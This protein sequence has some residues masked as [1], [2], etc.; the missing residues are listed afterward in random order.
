MTIDIARLRELCEKANINAQPSPLSVSDLSGRQFGRLTVAGWH[1]RGSKWK[2]HWTCVCSCG[3]LVVVS[4]DNL[5]RKSGTVSCGCWKR[6][7]GNPKHMMCY[8]TEYQIWSS[9]RKRCQNANCHAFKDY[10]ARGIFVSERW[11]T[12]ENFLA[13]MGRRP[14]GTTLDRIDNNGPYAK[15]NCRWATYGQQAR[16]TRQTKLTI[17]SVAEI[18]RLARSVPPAEM[19]ARYG[20]ATATIHSVIRGKSWVSP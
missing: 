19:A 5:K 8:S 2:S 7:K 20:V 10:G 18:R 16:N 9:M 1:S 17:E 15:G 4:I 13:D 6:S 11:Q 14:K 3:G 12:F